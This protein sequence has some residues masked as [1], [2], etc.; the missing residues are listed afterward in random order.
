MACPDPSE[1]L[2]QP[3]VLMPVE[4]LADCG[5]VAPNQL[6]KLISAVEISWV[7]N[8][9]VL[10]STGLSLSSFESEVSHSSAGSTGLL[11]SAHRTSSVVS[12]QLLMAPG[13]YVV[14]LKACARLR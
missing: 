13:L 7:D 9:M 11:E 3:V 4:K 12:L 5:F 2:S 14:P 8:S 1:K 10:S 6:V